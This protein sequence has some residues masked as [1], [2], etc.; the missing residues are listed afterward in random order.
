MQ[1]DFKEI[2]AY[3]D[4]RIVKRGA[5]YYAREM[6]ESLTQEGNLFTAKVAGSGKRP[7]TVEISIGADGLA[8]SWYC[9][10]PYDA[11][12]V[13]K[14]VVAV[15]LAIENGDFA[16]KKGGHEPPSGEKPPKAPQ[17]ALP[18]LVAK[19]SRQE[20]ELLLLEHAKQDERFCSNALSALGAPAGQ[21]L[22]AAKDL[23][24][25]SIRRN[26]H[27][28]SIDMRGCDAICD[29]MEDVLDEAQRHI[30]HGQYPPA[31]ALTQE[32]LVIGARLAS[33]AD[34]SSGS[35]GDTLGIGLKLLEDATAGLS[36]GETVEKRT[37]FDGILKA[38]K[39][40][41]FDG[42]GDWRYNLLNCAARLADKKSAPKLTALLDNLLSTAGQ[43]EYSRE[44]IIAATLETHFHLIHTMDG[45]QA[46]RA[47]L[48]QHLQFDRL[49]ELAVSL[50][51]E[52]G[53]YARAEALCL[54]K[55]EAVSPNPY[56]GPSRWHAL[57]CE[58]YRTT[59]QAEKL[60]A[61]LCTMLLLGKLDCYGELK[62]RLQA[63]KHWEQEYHPLLEAIAAARPRYEYM[64]IL[65]KESEF[66]LLMQQV[67]LLPSAVFTYGKLLAKQYP[68]Q[69]FSLC[70]PQIRV[71]AEHAQNRRDYQKLCALVSQL[72]D[73]G[74]VAEARRLIAELWE[75]YPR[76]SAL[77]EELKIAEAKVMR[78]S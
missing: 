19:A 46:A 72:A 42:W 64:Q 27:Q 40:K 71:A 78:R 37:A 62:C 66:A 49:R 28:G 6:I 57:L 47:F 68:E 74:G 4:Q 32:I 29:D 16:D 44:S 41:A 26:R 3:T 43:T 23:I 10:C 45:P 31:I 76:R 59:G 61:Q 36:A 21:E 33:E 53:E 38:A 60:T 12:D 58:I 54:E 11:G 51:M 13:C 1:Y 17:T 39:S 9:T 56:L 73:F 8:E 65:S 50:D 2:F 52:A 69:V 55:A 15:L 75:T 7:Y 22:A 63:T 30:A 14:H 25:A 5:E 77:R 48:T 35:L 18:D 67:Q 20:L 70:I 34:S 24:R